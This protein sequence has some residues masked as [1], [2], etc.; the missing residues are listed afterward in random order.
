M[1]PRTAI[2]RLLHGD[3]TPRG[4]AKIRS[5]LAGCP[6][7]RDYYDQQVVLLRALA[8]D[9]GQAHRDEEERVVRLAL[10]RSGAKLAA[11]T[12]SPWTRFTS[13]LVWHPLPW[14]VSMVAAAG[15]LLVALS[16]SRVAPSPTAAFAA[17][18]VQARGVTVE[19]GPGAEGREIGAG[20][21]VSVT[22]EGLAELALT[23]GGALKIFPGSSLRLGADGQSV[24]LARGKIWCE[25]DHTGKGFKVRT[26]TG[27]VRVV[28]T[29]F[30]VEHQPG[31]ATEVRV[32]HG[33]VELEDV[34]H[35]GTVRLAEAHQATLAASLAPSAP[36]SLIDAQDVSSW[37]ALR[38]GKPLSLPPPLPVPKEQEPDPKK[39][40]KIVPPQEGKRVE[41]PAKPMEKSATL[42]RP[43]KAPEKST[44]APRPA[45]EQGAEAPPAKAPERN[46]NLDEDARAAKQ[47]RK[48]AQLE[49]K[50]ERKDSR[51][52]QR[53]ELRKERKFK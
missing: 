40:E 36:A 23:R 18:L 21:T 46:E 32:F 38:S 3:S 29:S 2:H 13:S 52:E 44:P 42:P 39:P 4:E 30:V 6:S 20:G 43:A 22:A 16:S 26:T 49:R 51:T 35:R 17:R 8:G 31:A 10:T 19:G 48:D 9:P 5:H 53:K 34:G 50:V 14:G 45:P 1:H 12:P 11:F 28:G 37:E 33:L 27:E 41:A 47:D 25:I 7:C 24:E 15:L